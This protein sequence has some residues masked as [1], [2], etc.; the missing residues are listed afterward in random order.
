MLRV[1]PPN[2]EYE[3]CLGDGRVRGAALIALR[4]P[5][6]ARADRRIQ[7]RYP[8]DPVR[9]L[10]RLPWSGRRAPAGRP[11][12]GYRWRREVGER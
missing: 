7:S 11:P 6:A 8:A 2:V 12:P 10:F 5:G 3:A 4:D 9:P 1:T